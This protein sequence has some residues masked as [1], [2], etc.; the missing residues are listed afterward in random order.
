MRVDVRYWLRALLA[1]RATRN[2]SR[3]RAAVSPR[4]RDRAA[5][6]RWNALDEAQRTARLGFGNI[7][8]LKEESRDARGT[9]F[10]EELVADIGYALRLLRRSPGFAAVAILTL[11]MGIGLTTAIVSVVSAVIVRRSR[12]HRAIGSSWCFRRS[13]PMVPSRSRRSHQVISSNGGRRTQR[14]L[15]SVRLPAARSS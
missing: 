6:R 8:V 7:A 15:T 10:I 5:P 14:S 9:R 11:A 1:A 2:G 13:G 4:T 3:R 12:T